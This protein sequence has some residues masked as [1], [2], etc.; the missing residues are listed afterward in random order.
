[1]AREIDSNS[2]DASIGVVL[3]I[4]SDN[5]LPCQTLGSGR[6]LKDTLVELGLPGI[7]L[8]WGNCL[9]DI[10]DGVPRRKLSPL[11]KAI[12]TVLDSAVD[13]EAGDPEAA[14]VLKLFKVG[15]IAIAGAPEKT[16]AALRN[17]IRTS[18]PKTNRFVAAVVEKVQMRMFTSLR[19][20]PPD[21]MDAPQAQPLMKATTGG[22]K[23]MVVMSLAVEP[24]NVIKVAEMLSVADNAK[25][26]NPQPMP[27]DGLRE[28]RKRMERDYLG[29]KVLSDLIGEFEYPGSKFK[30]PLFDDR[31]D[32]REVTGAVGAG[33][34]YKAYM[35]VGVNASLAR[36]PRLRN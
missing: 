1:M 30:I 5:A 8:V 16:V 22:L 32:E 25:R 9:A 20:L 21:V 34:L 19:S 12:K 6:C 15:V 2:C 35:A 33:M 3:P 4:A 36:A 11:Q 26:E 29:I 7:R 18:E 10:V 24:D 13:R 31:A 23:V 17:E 27:W 28:V 14:E